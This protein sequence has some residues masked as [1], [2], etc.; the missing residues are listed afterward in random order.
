MKEKKFEKNLNLYQALISKYQIF[1][2]IH[3][4]NYVNCIAKI[5]GLKPI[6][7][8]S[9]GFLFLKEDDLKKNRFR[10]RIRKR[11]PPKVKRLVMNRTDKIRL[12]NELRFGKKNLRKGRREMIYKKYIK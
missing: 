3:N 6:G 5:I 1:D 12:M 11:K 10:A 7:L 9:Y 4:S 8:Q 2:G